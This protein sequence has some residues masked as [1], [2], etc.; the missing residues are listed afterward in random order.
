MMKP[1]HHLIPC[2][3]VKICY[4]NTH[5]KC[6]KL[7]N[8]P[9]PISD[10]NVTMF[11]V[12]PRFPAALDVRNL[13]L[14]YGFHSTAKSWGM[15]SFR[16]LCLVVV[17]GWNHPVMFCLLVWMSIV[18]GWRGF[19]CSVSTDFFFRVEAPDV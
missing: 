9:D 15:F 8:Q 16:E 1:S 10:V 13:I 5:T 14:G 3:N 4:G 12:L 18:V 17:G 2:L 7:E 19:V 6:C 11:H